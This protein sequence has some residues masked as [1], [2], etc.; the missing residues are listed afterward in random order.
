MVAVFRPQTRSMIL[1][2]VSYCLSETALV[3]SSNVMG[4]SMA[5]RLIC[6]HS[7]S[8]KHRVFL[9]RNQSAVIT[10]YHC[11]Y[12]LSSILSND[13]QS[14]SSP[15]ITLY[16]LKLVRC[17]SASQLKL[18]SDMN[19][20]S[21]QLGPD[22]LRSLPSMCEQF[23]RRFSGQ[24]WSQKPRNRCIIQSRGGTTCRT[25]QHL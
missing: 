10:T 15:W 23:R 8:F 14:T 24:M 19:S 13:F 16:I 18:F 6:N 17:L 7:P 12:C 22:L 3:I 20:I 25:G 4:V 2:L 21:V 1:E 11:L 9:P 5:Q